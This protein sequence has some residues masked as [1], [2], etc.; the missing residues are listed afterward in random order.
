MNCTAINS[1]DWNS[2]SVWQGGNVPGTNDTITIN[3]GI[4]V[5]I[6]SSKM[7]YNG[8]GN[9]V[10]L[11][12]AG[13]SGSL[14]ING[15]INVNV[16]SIA[17]GSPQKTGICLYNDSQVVINTGGVLNIIATGLDNGA[18]YNANGMSCSQNGKI[19]NNGSVTI[20][21]HNNTGGIGFGIY[22][23]DDNT[24]FINNA[25]VFISQTDF[26]KDGRGHCYGFYINTGSLINT[27]TITSDNTANGI[28]RIDSSGI[29][30]NN[31]KIVNSGRI[32]NGG[33]INNQGTITS[34]LPNANYQ[35]NNINNQSN[36]II[37]LSGLINSQT[38]LQSI[39]PLA[40]NS[41]VFIN[42]GDTLT[43][44]STFTITSGYTLVCKGILVNNSSIANAGTVVWDLGATFTPSNAYNSMYLIQG[45]TLQL[46]GTLASNATLD[47]SQLCYNIKSVSVL[48][49]L[50]I[51]S[52]ST[53]NLASLIL[54][55]PSS[56]SLTIL[57][58]GILETTQPITNNGTLTINGNLLWN[59]SP[60]VAS[61]F[62]GVNPAGTGSVALTGTISSNFSFSNI[63]WSKFSIMS[64]E[65]LTI[66]QSGFNFSTTDEFIISSNATLE[67]CT[68]VNILSILTNLGTVNLNGAD[69]RVTSASNFDNDNGIITASRNSI[70]VWDVAGTFSLSNPVTGLYQFYIHGNNSSQDIQLNGYADINTQFIIGNPEN[71]PE[72][73]YLEN[74]VINQ[75]YKLNIN[76]SLN[77]SSEFINDDG[78]L[79]INTSNS[80]SFSG[81][82]NSGSIWIFNNT[83]LGNIDNDLLNFFP[84]L[85]GCTDFQVDNNDHLY[86]GNDTISGVNLTING[87]V[88]VVMGKTLNIGNPATGKSTV[89]VAGSLD[90][91]RATIT[92]TNTQGVGLHFVGK[93]PA[94]NTGTLDLSTGVNATLNGSAAAL[95]LERTLLKNNSIS[96]TGTIT[97][98]PGNNSTIYC[99]QGTICGG[100]FSPNIAPV[101]SA[102][103]GQSATYVNNC[104]DN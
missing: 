17:G 39:V 90:N 12:A 15:T 95:Y 16:I 86:I 42:A 44:N 48:S 24:Q 3:T 8:F 54:T 14:T 31:G 46:Q 4:T 70:F 91:T 41:T 68:R 40:N 52:G 85:T 72:V 34:V 30:Q 26:E 43:N 7:G 19:T 51:N 83:V 1:G 88:T 93:D 56:I 66:T 45:G 58:G 61:P 21:A 49:N 6:D 2:P 47:L 71:S 65:T 36:G 60:Q 33:V 97:N 102:I 35:G 101:G 23:S 20:S 29:V 28:F 11:G 67:L 32:N 75:G 64:G 53:L 27:G 5:S 103:T 18:T 76:S 22:L 69:L 59:C 96:G 10:Q 104:G 13:T 98:K 25:N 62:S 94:F 100:T 89:K 81:V 57:S 37:S 99:N 80:Y 63:N 92:V 82:E 87:N 55:I 73:V 38:N 9:L 79:R 77:L 78:I 84:L 50:S 74:L